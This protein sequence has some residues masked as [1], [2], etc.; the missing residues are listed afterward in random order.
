MDLEAILR[1]PPFNQVMLDLE[2]R[3]S[4]DWMSWKIPGSIW[5]RMVNMLMMVPHTV[6]Y[7]IFL[8]GGEFG[9]YFGCVFELCFTKEPEQDMRTVL[10][11]G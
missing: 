2:H 5:W 10:L 4:G 1:F 6:G 3:G 7:L 11:L 8:W 9:R